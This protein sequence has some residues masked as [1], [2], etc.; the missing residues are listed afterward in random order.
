MMSVSVLVSGRPLGPRSNR[1]NKLREAGTGGRATTTVVALESC[2]C[3]LLA[4][5]CQVQTSAGSLFCILGSMMTRRDL[6]R[7]LLQCPQ[8]AFCSCGALWSVLMMM[9]ALPSTSSLS[10]LHVFALMPY[11]N[12]H[13]KFACAQHITPYRDCA[14]RL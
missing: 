10:V 12:D 3:R 1:V 8:L 7:C 13:R 4:Q 14:G 2:G 9:Y 6:L 11:N 5:T